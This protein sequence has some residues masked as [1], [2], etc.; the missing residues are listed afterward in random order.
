MSEILKIIKERRSIRRY[1]PDP[2]PKDIL[3]KVIEA[4]CWAP[5]YM[6]WQNWYYVVVGGEKKKKLF[7]YLEDSFK[8][9]IECLEEDISEGVKKRTSF[10][11]D[12]ANDAPNIIAVFS[13]VDLTTTPEALFSVAA[14][15]E[16]L[17]LTA[18]SLGLGACWVSSALYIA[19]DLSEFL[20]IAD[21]ELVGLIT[22]GYPN[23]YPEPSPRKSG[24][25]RWEGVD[26]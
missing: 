24:R 18:H 2:I 15:V 11:L 3:E 5:S 16:N 13:D 21:K 19:E 14:S 17:L 7:S 20:G 9:I 25:V 22:I 4:A 6:D 1:K 26:G 12:V 10:F 23:E 8:K